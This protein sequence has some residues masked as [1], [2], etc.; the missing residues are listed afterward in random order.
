MGWG[1]L[2]VLHLSLVVPLEGVMPQTI[3]QEVLDA[4]LQHLKDDGE[5]YL[6]CLN[7]KPLKDRTTA[8]EMRDGLILFHHVYLFIKNNP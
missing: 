4:E 6:E 5:R 7:D 2:F 8:Q 1:V 3:P